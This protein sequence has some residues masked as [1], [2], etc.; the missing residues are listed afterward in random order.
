MEFQYR[1]NNERFWSPFLI[2]IP[3]SPSVWRWIP[4]DVGDRSPSPLHDPPIRW[5]AGKAPAFV[6]RA[7]SRNGN[8]RQSRQKHGISLD[9]EL[10][11]SDR[12]GLI[13]FPCPH[14]FSLLSLEVLHAFWQMVAIGRCV[15]ASGEVGQVMEDKAF[16]QY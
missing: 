14:V 2:Y 13:L 12:A 6:L 11:D 10:M 16:C 7:A 3:I 4:C 1:I 9:F 15:R 5:Q 8:R